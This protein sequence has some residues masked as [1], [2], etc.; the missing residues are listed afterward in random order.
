MHGLTTSSSRCWLKYAVFLQFPKAIPK[1]LS[2]ETLAFAGDL[3]RKRRKQSQD[4]CFLLPASSF[5]TPRKV[6][7]RF[8][9]NTGLIMSRKLKQ[10]SCLAQNQ[11]NDFHG[12]N[13]CVLTSTCIGDFRQ[14]SWQC[15]TPNWEKVPSSVA[16]YF[17]NS[18]SCDFF[19]VLNYGN[20]LP[21]KKPET[22]I[23]ENKDW[24]KGTKRGQTNPGQQIRNS[25]L[26]V[27]PEPGQ[28]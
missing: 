20:C 27:V 26:E 15:H 23:P 7:S 24:P 11:Q 3:Y 16:M 13:H 17:R 25:V 14:P 28:S 10:L 1:R 2:Q 12:P 19:G 5:Q 21:E 9:L 22:K 18:G 4:P 6:L 8:P